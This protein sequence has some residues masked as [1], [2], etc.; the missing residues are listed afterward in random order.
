MPYI[1]SKTKAKIR[2]I[3]NSSTLIQDGISDEIV[4]CEIGHEDLIWLLE[5]AEKIAKVEHEVENSDMGTAVENI[6]TI[7]ES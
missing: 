2:K 1:E 7:V 6:I 5:Q 4:G 3:R